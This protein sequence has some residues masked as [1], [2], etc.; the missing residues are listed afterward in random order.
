MRTTP[1]QF[2]K[3]VSLV[4]F[5]LA[6]V[7]QEP[8]IGAPFRAPAERSAEVSWKKPVALAEVQIVFDT[9]LSSL[10]VPKPMPEELVRDYTVEALHAGKWEIV[11]EEK[12]NFLRLRRHVVPTGSE[13][14]A[15]RVTVTATW[16]S[17]EARILEL[18]ALRP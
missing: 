4:A 1:F 8:A 12:D 2:G 11:A 13:V 17:S 15:L 6:A 10:I 7:A 3:Y 9:H 14:S 18:R 5:L 16:G